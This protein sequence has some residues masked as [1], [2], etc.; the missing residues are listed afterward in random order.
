MRSKIFGLSMALAA[1][2]ALAATFVAGS[3]SAGEGAMLSGDAYETVEAQIERDGAA[4]LGP[5]VTTSAKCRKTSDSR[6]WIL[7]PPRYGR[8]A[9]VERRGEIAY[10]EDQRYAYC[11]DLGVTGTMIR[12]APARGFVGED[13]FV[14][15]VKFRDGEVRTKRVNVHVE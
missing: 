3:A 8:A 13:S 15:R 5:F 12:Y 1:A 6:G 14:F 2:S 7:E 10:G 9:V 11:N 4:F